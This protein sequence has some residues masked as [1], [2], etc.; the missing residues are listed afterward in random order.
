MSINAPGP[1]LKVEVLFYCPIFFL[2]F[3]VLRL[4][5]FRPSF[6]RIRLTN[7]SLRFWMSL[8]LRFMVLRGPQRIWARAGWEVME[9][10]GTRSAAR[11]SAVCVWAGVANVGVKGDRDGL[12]KAVVLEDSVGRRGVKEV[13]VL[14]L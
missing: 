8:V 6:V 10:L 5:I 2:P 13:K 14:R 9:L 4:I 1:G 12:T 11:P 3:S 7:P